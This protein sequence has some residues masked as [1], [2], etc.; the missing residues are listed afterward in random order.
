MKVTGYALIA[1]G[2]LLGLFA[3]IGHLILGVSPTEAAGTVQGTPQGG[4]NYW[5]A[6]IPAAISF[7]VGLWMVLTKHKGYQETYDVRKQQS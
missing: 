5:Y 2:V 7:G 4:G 3:M 6:L 1:I